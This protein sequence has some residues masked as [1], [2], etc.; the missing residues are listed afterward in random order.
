MMQAGAQDS[1][2][3]CRAPTKLRPIAKHPDAIFIKHKPCI[4]RPLEQIAYHHS[5][6]KAH[7]DVGTN[8]LLACWHVLTEA[9]VNRE[10]FAPTQ[11]GC[12]A[13]TDQCY[14]HNI[15]LTSQWA[16]RCHAHY[17]GP[18]RGPCSA[19]CLFPRNTEPGDG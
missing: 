3:L 14:C 6:C 15:R 2:K 10:Q 18:M 19:N 11:P 5:P 8:D 7:I 4:P 17:W 16:S 1:S 9:C 13:T 12:L